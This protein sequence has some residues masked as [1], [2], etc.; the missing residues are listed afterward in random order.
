MFDA[1]SVPG[2][3]EVSRHC[4]KSVGLVPRKRQRPAVAPDKGPVW[5]LGFGGDAATNAGQDSDSLLGAMDVGIA[6]R[7]SAGESEVTKNT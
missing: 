5:H 6:Y 3:N 2:S 7:P 4:A 1:Y